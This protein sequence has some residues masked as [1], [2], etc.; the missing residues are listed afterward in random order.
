MEKIMWLVLGATVMV[1]SLHA[2]RS[3]RARL[4]AR[5]ALGVLFLVFGAMVNAIYLVT[6]WDSFAAFGEM[7]QIAFVRDT[8]ASLFVTNTGLFIGL[9]IAGEATA[10]ILVLFGGRPMQAGLV[11]LMAFHLGLLFFGWW[12]W[13]YAVPILGALSLLLRAELRHEPR[14]AIASRQHA[15]G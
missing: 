11:M 3:Q 8:W 6:A 4:V 14:Q 12:L 9:L 13:L 2:D 10:G 5:I 1:A 7:S 15:T